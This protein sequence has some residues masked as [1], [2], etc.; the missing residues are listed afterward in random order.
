MGGAGGAKQ[1][2]ELSKCVKKTL[3][4]RWKKQHPK[5]HTPLYLELLIPLKIMLKNYAKTSF[6]DSILIHFFAPPGVYWITHT[7][8][9]IAQKLCKNDQNSAKNSIFSMKF[10]YTFMRLQVDIELL[11]PL[12]KVSKCSFQSS[13]VKWDFIWYATL[14]LYQLTIS[15]CGVTFWKKL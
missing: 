3:Y 7:P 6:F 2:L 11:I 12:N 1:H 13:R 5:T 14:I 9:N 10:W 8:Q 15:K 4:F